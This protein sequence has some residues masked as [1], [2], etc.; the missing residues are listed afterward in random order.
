MTWPS[1][2]RSVMPL[3]VL[4]LWRRRPRDLVFTCPSGGVAVP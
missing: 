3:R 4:R 1:R 2:L